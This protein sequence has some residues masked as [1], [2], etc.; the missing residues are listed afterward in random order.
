M[1]QILRKISEFPEILG[2]LSM[3]KQCVPGSFLST[4]ALEPGNEANAVSAKGCSQL[5]QCL[6]GTLVLF[7]GKLFGEKQPVSQYIGASYSKCESCFISSLPSMFTVFNLLCRQ[8]YCVN[9]L[10]WQLSCAE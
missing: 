7:M 10:C 8:F 1:E 2:E 5:T 6:A 3:R 4:H 9:L